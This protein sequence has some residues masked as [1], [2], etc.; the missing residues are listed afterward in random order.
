MQPYEIMLMA[1]AA[2]VGLSVIALIVKA[3]IWT[4][5]D[6]RKRGL[7]PVWLFQLLVVVEF[8]WP[9]LVY[10]LVTRNLDRKAMEQVV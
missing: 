1:F 7:S 4:G 6:A 5:H 3:V 9:W 10:Y 8:P 2:L